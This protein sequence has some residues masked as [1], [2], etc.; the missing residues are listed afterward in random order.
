MSS[1][2]LRAVRSRILLGCASRKA[3]ALTSADDLPNS[4]LMRWRE[5]SQSGAK[6]ITCKKQDSPWRNVCRFRATA[7]G[8]RAPC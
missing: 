6:I 7:I 1:K 2:T 3:P 8:R 5:K 4:W